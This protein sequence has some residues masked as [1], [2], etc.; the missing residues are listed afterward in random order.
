MLQNQPPQVCQPEK[1]YKIKPP[2]T[3][4][5]DNSP[6]DITKSTIPASRYSLYKVIGTL[7]TWLS[8][9][10]KSTTPRPQTR[11]KI[12]IVKPGLEKTNDFVMIRRDLIE[13]IRYDTI[14]LTALTLRHHVSF[15]IFLFFMF[16]QCPADHLHEPTPPS[17][18]SNCKRSTDR[19]NMIEQSLEHLGTNLDHGWWGSRT[20]H[21]KKT[22]QRKANASHH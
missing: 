19:L 18:A 20:C 4:A 8:T 7:S 2:R 17:H 10:T 15:L 12:S 14:R 13:M 6:A 9:I 22:K 1:L 21:Q 3:Q 16:S 11:Y 5:R